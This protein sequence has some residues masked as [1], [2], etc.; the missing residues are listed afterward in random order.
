MDRR[1]I[2]DN[3]VNLCL[4][5]TCLLVSVAVAQ[6]LWQ[7]EPVAPGSRPSVQYEPGETMAALPGVEYATAPKTLVLVLSS[8]CRYC[9]ESMPFYLKLAEMRAS[10][11]YRMVVVG[12]ETREVLSEYL[13][14]HKL[15]PDAVISAASGTLKVSGTP[16]LILV[17]KTGAVTAQWS[18][19]LRGREQ[20]VET[21]LQLVA[22]SVPGL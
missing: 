2:V 9:T 13:A 11:S 5:V 22:T 15:Q 4:V 16:T 18:G 12:L 19:A 10:A 20:E 6:R 17:E 21:A 8:Q 1:R 7:G 3:I 14:S